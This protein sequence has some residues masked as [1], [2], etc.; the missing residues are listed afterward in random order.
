MAGPYRRRRRRAARRTDAAV[1]L[2]RRRLRARARPLSDRRGRLSRAGSP[3][4]V[5]APVRRRAETSC[6][7]TRPRSSRPTTSCRD[8]PACTRSCRSTESRR[9][10]TPTA[11]SA[12]SRPSSNGSL[13][14][15]RARR[16]G[17]FALSLGPVVTTPD[18]DDSAR[19]RLGASARARGREHAPLSRR[20]ARGMRVAVVG[21]GVMGCAAAWA[22]R[23]RG[24]DVVVYEQFELDNTRGS[25][26]GR[27]RIFRVAY[28]DPYWIR[29]AQEAYAGW[30]DLDPER[31][32]ALRPRRARARSG[33]DLGAR[34]RRVRC[35]VPAARP[36]SRESSVPHGWTAL[37]VADAGVVF[38]DRARHAFLD[39]VD[40]SGRT[41]ASSRVDDV[42]ADVVVVTAGAW[43]GRLVPDVPV[44]VT[45][46]TVAYFRHEGP[47]PAVGRRHRR[48]RRRTTCTRCYDPVHGLKA[49]AHHAGAETD[50]DDD[51]APDPADRR[52]H[53]GVGG[54][55]LPRRRPQSRSR[56]TRASTRRR[57]D[58]TFVLERRG[59][60]VVGSACSGHG[61]K[62]APAVGR[63]LAELA[64]DE[65]A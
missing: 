54:R 9:S 55:A 26:H 11:R 10:S 45:R 41:R 62:F 15:S 49:G 44:R 23:E 61:F 51:G 33:A 34:A 58:Q 63:R 5:R 40:V 8:R 48:G 6:S 39:G 42:D 21:A 24:A 27:T 60:V 20:P 3:S 7:R 50:P 47:P 37:Q 16:R 32:R 14:R 28:P 2:R 13:R 65:F 38:S 53:R 17:D 52:A 4:A 46:E 25:S 30:N 29:F 35:R 43:V 1:V 31:A 59:N 36:T 18:E 22:L 19:H 57:R 56:R 12:G 64:L